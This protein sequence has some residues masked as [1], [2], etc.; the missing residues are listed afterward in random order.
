MH[1]DIASLT[2][3]PREMFEFGSPCQD[4]LGAY[5]QGIVLQCQEARTGALGTV[6]VLAAAEVINGV[7]TYK[8]P[9]G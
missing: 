9:P 4:I 1:P 2:A 8:L 5:T 3:L 7:L 6:F